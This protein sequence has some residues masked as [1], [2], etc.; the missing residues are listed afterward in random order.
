M[1]ADTHPLYA[2]TH[3]SGDAGAITS[4]HQLLQLTHGRASEAGRPC[5]DR[6]V[7]WSTQHQQTR[8]RDP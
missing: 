5:V 6:P 4:H 2:Q 1:H 7:M 8:S 3:P